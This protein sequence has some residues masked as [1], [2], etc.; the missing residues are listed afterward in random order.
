MPPPLKPEAVDEKRRAIIASARLIA[1]QQGLEAAKMSDIARDAHVSKG[2]LYRF[3]E[4]KEDLLLAVVL[5]GQAELVPLLAE[6]RQS[7]GSSVDR[8]VGMAEIIVQTL[9]P[10]VDR[11]VVDIQAVGLAARD[12][13]ARSRLDTANRSAYDA[14]HDELRAVIKEGIATGLLRPDLDADAA[15]AALVA[16]RDGVIYRA[17]FD[18]ARKQADRAR[19]VFRV[20]V[21]GMLCLQ[22]RA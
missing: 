4:S 15:A 2:T 10:A 16:V 3:F 12:S 1:S 18:E 20:V 9:A 5:E 19:A 11:V 6:K 21:D 8:L 13:S 14:V 22:K 17:S 7:A